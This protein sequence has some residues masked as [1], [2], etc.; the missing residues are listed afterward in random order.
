MLSR[1][2]GLIRDIVFGAL[3]SRFATDAFSIAFLI[4]NLLRRL[5]AEGIISTAFIPV[6]TGY[7]QQS[8]TEKQRAYGAVLVVFSMV[9]LA[10]TVVGIIISPWLVPLFASGFTAPKLQLTIELTQLMFPFLFLVGLTSFWTALLHIRRHFTAPALGPV[11]LNLGIIGC[12]VSLRFLFPESRTILAMAWG[13]LVGGILQLVLQIWMARREHVVMQPHWAPK[14]PAV[15]EVTGLMMPTLLGLGVYQLNLLISNS[16]A[17]YLPTGSVTYIYYSNRLME[18]PLG[19]FA[20]A[21]ATVNLPTLATQAENKAWED[22]QQTMERGMRGVLFLCIPAAFGLFLLREPIITILFQHGRFVAADTLATAQVFGPAAFGLIFAGMLRNLTPAFYAIKDTRTPVK[23]AVISLVL[24]ASLSVFF[25][26]VLRWQ[27]TGL[28]LANTCS[29]LGSVVVSLYYMQ[30][31][32]PYSFRL[33]WWDIS[34]PLLLVSG[35]MA[36]VLW[37]G[38]RPFSWQSQAWWMRVVGLSGLIALG[39]VTF[40]LGAWWLKIPEMTKLIGK[41]RRR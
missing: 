23:I 7:Q 32:F 38:M 9:L 35:V 27:A 5:L 20:V 24:N 29:T 37:G 34:R 19:V 22:F 25:G 3:F 16:L 1:M 2:L 41:L 15:Q 28:T 30:R 40:A 33:P 39:G 31:T 13:V 8:E 14:H 11:F 36:L 10:A 6:F 26:F 18:L 4:P 21:F 12:A 17:S